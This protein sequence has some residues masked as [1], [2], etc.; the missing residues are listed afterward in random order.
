MRA[1]LWLGLLCTAQPRCAIDVSSY[2]Q[3][4]VALYSRSIRVS[5]RLRSLQREVRLRSMVDVCTL[6]DDEVTCRRARG[7]M[8]EPSAKAQP[9]CAAVASR[10]VKSEY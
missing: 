5:A 2:V 8:V 4:S 1:G 6:V 9:R 10:H 7:A 3:C